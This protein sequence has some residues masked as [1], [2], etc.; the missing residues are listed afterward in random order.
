MRKENMI[1]IVNTSVY[2]EDLRDGNR[3]C[4]PFAA[5]VVVVDEDFRKEKT[6]SRIR[7]KALGFAEG[8]TGSG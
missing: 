1:R 5:I 4:L 6:G 3:E 8:R 7:G 2:E